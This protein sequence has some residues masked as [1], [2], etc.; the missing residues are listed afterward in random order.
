MSTPDNRHI[1]DA[2]FVASLER[3]VLR[4]YRAESPGMAIG[5]TPRPRWREQWRVAAALIIGLAFGTGAQMA[6]AQVQDARTR[7]ELERSL[8]VDRQVLAL[9][10]QLAQEE[11]DRVR[12]S[13][14]AGAI[15]QQSLR[16]AANELR[17]LQSALRRLELNHSEVQLTS[18]A[19]RDELWAPLVQ[20]RDFVT[21]RLQ[22]EAELVQQLLSTAESHHAEI[23]RAIGMGAASIGDMQSAQM[24][25]A[26]AKRRF[27]LVAAQLR[28]RDQVLANKLTPDEATRRLQFETMQ[29]EMAQAQQALTIGNERLALAR[30]QMAAGTLTELEVKRLE[31]DI[32]EQQIRLD[33][34]KAE[35]RSRLQSGWQFG[36]NS[37]DTT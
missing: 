9:R 32:M 2:H 36:R 1:P 4:T 15:S 24:D 3:E 7:G 26:G 18:T 11:L 23:A 6:S 34:M 21:Q 13:F 35:M 5:L 19:P 25:V 14:N 27:A 29:L 16:E 8:D 30:Q 10:V 33:R 37:R 31:L 22:L 28:I 20:G 12:T 17:S